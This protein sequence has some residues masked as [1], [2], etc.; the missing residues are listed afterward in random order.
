MKRFSELLF[1]IFRL[2]SSFVIVTVSSISLFGQSIDFTTEP[3]VIYY[4]CDHF[5][6]SADSTAPEA[7]SA[8][9]TVS[10]Y[11]YRDIMQDSLTKYILFIAPESADTTSADIAQDVFTVPVDSMT[12]PGQRSGYWMGSTVNGSKGN[13][14]KL[15]DI[16]GREVETLE[17]EQKP[18]GNYRIDFTAS[19]L[20]SGVYFYRMK[21]GDYVTTKKLVLMK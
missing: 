8:L 2:S 10:Y 21:A 20:S 6:L 4:G 15:Y 7:D 11:I 19:K 16:L 12:Q 13:Y 17:N 5:S 9:N 18:P 1:F 3:T 14:T